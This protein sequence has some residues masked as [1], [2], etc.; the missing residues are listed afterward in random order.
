MYRRND[1]AI[2]AFCLTLLVPTQLVARDDGRFAD[3]P[4]KP[5]LDRLASRN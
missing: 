4:L 1:L 3:S 2:F 5:W